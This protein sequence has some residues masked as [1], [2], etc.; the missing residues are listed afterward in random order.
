MP[1]WR[2]GVDVHKYNTRTRRYVCPF[3]N[4]TL[5]I[6][7]TK[8]CLQLAFLSGPNYLPFFQYP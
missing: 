2:G 3:S 1:G 4:Y 5:V 7:L 6:T 8:P